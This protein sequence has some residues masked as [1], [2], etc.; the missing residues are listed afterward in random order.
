MKSNDIVE[1]DGSQGEGGGQV[2]RTSL[3]LSLITGKPF[4]L[5]NIRAKRP[6]PGLMRQHLACVEAAVAIGGGASQT[7]ARTLAGETPRLG[8]QSL[9]FT[10]GAVVPGDYRFAI[11]S[12]GSCMR[13]LQTV[14]WPLVLANAPSTVHLSGG[15]HN[16]MAP[17]AT[18][19]QATAPTFAAAMGMA[20]AP[21]NLDLRR[22]GFYPAGGGEVVAHITPKQLSKAVS[23]FSLHERGTSLAAYATCLHAGVPGN[24]AVRELARL[25]ERLGWDEANLRN[26]GL[27]A[28]EGP[29]NALEV[30]L[31]YENVTEVFT[32]YGERGV[33]AERVADDLA[34]EVRRYLAGSAPVGPYLADQLKLPLALAGAGEYLTADITPHSR[35]NAEVIAKFLGDTLSI[36]EA[37]G[38]WRVRAG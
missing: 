16:P 9:W 29:G 22:H 10:P 2:L 21:F 4:R 3:A 28:N 8:A 36:D 15:T 13:V 25:K 12:A 23:P 20:D 37:A 38:A 27:R 18:F 24:V 1:I 5:S 32:H 17:S 26:R 34:R 35:T 7:R 30:T 14:L 33:S 6:K 11:G 31:Q 19:L